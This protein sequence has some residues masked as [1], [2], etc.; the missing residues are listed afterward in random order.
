LTRTAA[1]LAVLCAG[2]CG[3]ALA[4]TAPAPAADDDRTNVEKI[5]EAHAAQA[6][7]FGELFEKIDRV[8]GEEYVEDRDRK[9]QVRAGAETTFNAE[10]TN[11]DSALRFGV[12]LP[13]PALERGR[14]NLFLEIGEDVNDLGAA[15]NPSFDQS[16]KRLAIAAALVARPREELETGLKLHVFWE[17][18]SFASVYPF[19]RFERKRAPMRYFFEQR[20]I[21]E[22]ENFWRTRTD[23]DLDRTLGSGMFVRLR[24]R[25]DHVFGDPGL[26][27]AH[28]LIL[29]QLVFANRG[30]SCELWLEYN[31]AGDDPTTFD[32]DTIAYAQLRWRGRVWRNW[33]EYELRPAYTIV[34]DSDRDP[35]YSFFVSLTV[36]WDSFLGGSGGHPVLPDR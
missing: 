25:A 16:R 8:F 9:I 1:I 23:L 20:L 30:L 19:V 11:T 13:L 29:R 4:D 5:D 32:D 14:A 21:W 2:W 10:G 12:R 28:G 17:D 22:S 6:D 36:I 34:L 15:S 31:S 35:F 18:G 7:Y 24:N 3:S 26:Q 27:V 33:L